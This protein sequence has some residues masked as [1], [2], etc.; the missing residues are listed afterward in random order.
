MVAIVPSATTMTREGTMRARFIAIAAVG[1]STGGHASVSSTPFELGGQ[2]GWSHD[3][4]HAGGFFHTYDAFRPADV[5]APRKIHVFLP[6]DYQTTTA[7]YPVVYMNDGQTAFFP[8][9]AI[10]K[11][12]DA[13]KVLSEL[14]ARKLIRP[15]IVVAIH[16]LDRDREYTHEEVLPDRPYGGLHGYGDY[17]ATS[18]KPWIDAHY[19]TLS[20]RDD[21]GII[22]SSHGGLAAFFVASRHSELFGFAGC[23]SPSF[24]VGLE[25]GPHDAN[26]RSSSLLKATATGLARRPR[27]WIDWGLVRDG[28]FHNSWIEANAAARG[29]EMADLLVRD[30]GY[31]A[32]EDLVL[33]EDPQGE[34][35]E[36][37]WGRRLP[38]VLQALVGH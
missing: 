35:T 34:H 2:H 6:R 27:F 12:W 14:Y 20:G 4:G 32:G 24:W 22:G 18:L 37:S 33:H 36:D 25:T 7:R 29:R 23:L 3:E 17:V 19:R 5:A 26:L 21:T 31:R 9:G 16:A 13:A 11:S 38:L 10:G 28:G 8:G 30:F 15:V 1:I